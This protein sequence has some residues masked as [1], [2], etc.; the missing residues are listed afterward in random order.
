MAKHTSHEQ[1]NEF[2]EKQ[3]TN[4]E[5]STTGPAAKY[6]SMRRIQG[7]VTKDVPVTSSESKSTRWLIGRVEQDS[8]QHECAQH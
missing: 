1:A 5:A 6:D 8:K 4:F 7:D 3:K 2:E